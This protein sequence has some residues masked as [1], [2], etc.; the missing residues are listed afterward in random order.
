MSFSFM[1]SKDTLL[2]VENNSTMCFISFFPIK[3]FFDFDTITI[4]QK[5]ANTKKIQQFIES[6]STFDPG[7][8]VSPPLGGSVYKILSLNSSKTNLQKYQLEKYRNNFQSIFSNKVFDVDYFS[9]EKEK[10]M[11]Q[12]LIKE[13]YYENTNYL[14]I[15]TIIA[16]DELFRIFGKDKVYNIFKNFTL[17]T[18][19]KHKEPLELLLKSH[20]KN[21]DFDFLEE[22]I[23][24]ESFLELLAKLNLTEPSMGVNDINF[25]NLQEYTSKELQNIQIDILE[26]K[27]DKYST[28]IIIKSDSIIINSSKTNYTDTFFPIFQGEKVSYEKKDDGSFIVELISKTQ[29]TTIFEILNYETIEIGNEKRFYKPFVLSEIPI[30]FDPKKPIV[31]IINKILQKN[32]FRDF[33]VGLE[34]IKLPTRKTISSINTVKNGYIAI[35]Q[36]PT[37][38]GFSYDTS[39]VNSKIQSLESMLF[40]INDGKSFVKIRL[41]FNAYINRFIKDSDFQHTIKQEFMKEDLVWSPLLYNLKDLCL[42][43]ILTSFITIEEYSY[44]ISSL[45]VST[46]IDLYNGNSYLNDKLDT[47]TSDL[48]IIDNGDIYTKSGKKIQSINMFE[49]NDMFNGLVIAP[50]GSGKSFLTCHLIDGFM[51]GVLNND[52]IS[53]IIDRGGSYNNFSSV[54]GGV[55]IGI[56]KTDSTNCI[57][58][59]IFS[60]YFAKLLK[61][62]LLLNDCKII[63]KNFVGGTDG[64]IRQLKI[65]YDNLQLEI[66]EILS[67]CV[68]IEG[69]LAPDDTIIRNSEG[70]VSDTLFKGTN[71]QD[72]MEIWIGLILDMIGEDTISPE[73]SGV[74]SRN[75]YK[76]FQAMIALKSDLILEN[77]EPMYLL[78]NDIAIELRN[79]ILMD[80]QEGFSEE[81]LN[82][83][84]FQLEEYINPLQSGKLFNSAPTLDFSKTKLSNLDFGEIQNEKLSNLVL[85]SLVLQFF[86]I[87]T[88]KKYKTSKKLLVIDE[89]HAVLNS[90]YT[91]GLKSVSYLF[92]T[93]RKHGAGV[94]LLSQ[95]IDDFVK[96]KGEVEPIKMSQFSGIIAN[97]G[98]KW[99]LG[100]HPKSACM[101]RLDLPE[102]IANRIST[103]SSREFFTISKKYNFSEMMVSN[104]T[105]AISTTHKEEKILINSLSSFSGNNKSGLLLFSYL[106]GMGFV[107]K[108]S[109]TKNLLREYGFDSSVEPN[110]KLLISCLRDYYE[111]LPEEKQ[112]E[113]IELNTIFLNDFDKNLLLGLLTIIELFDL[114]LKTKEILVKI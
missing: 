8:M 110:T 6:L 55:N 108:Y 36:T 112:E 47:K 39:E 4:E 107:S 70:K 101:N 75:L 24:I 22:N 78:L 97:A 86:S 43:Y 96:E 21:I 37:F 87:M 69:Y 104:M 60:N 49:S 59:F 33:V 35:S 89:A 19:S 62:E 7:S 3:K 11:M 50:S 61:I 91:S 29:T 25:K 90:S 105:Y 41:T 23:N 93:A 65:D 66:E 20:Y 80:E 18:Y 106:F 27:T 103:N 113:L 102:D 42:P 85:V 45:E 68:N 74:V 71:I 17:D 46:I 51:S 10:S 34:I 31:Q 79:S 58:P 81:T 13:N 111:D 92:R 2:T 15:K 28:Y 53:M 52:N 67:T 76:V 100:R 38:G 40:H 64:A 72:V 56:N 14:C 57:N 83:Y 73:N 77:E 5:D 12:E 63:E 95:S 44:N 48:K 99:L 82:K 16:Q 94:L 84:L 9:F 98:I 109:N 1:I 30:V 54:S 114:K 26:N 88:S 32:N